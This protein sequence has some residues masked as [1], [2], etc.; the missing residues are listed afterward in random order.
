MDNRAPS[1]PRRR[2]FHLSD[3]M[4]TLTF[5]ERARTSAHKR[6]YGPRWRRARL[7][8]LTAHP[9]CVMCEQLG[10]TNPAT[11]VDHKI[12]H[13]RD[14][15]LFWN[16]ANW[17]SLCAPCHD[18]HKQSQERTG[19]MRGACADGM[20]IDPAHPWHDKG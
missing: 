15:V 16:E 7:L 12:P 8:Y 18:R 3:V 17:Q 19:S 20:P 14:A 13:R 5:Y 1:V 9:L 2:G 11:V 6:G 4:A 10:R